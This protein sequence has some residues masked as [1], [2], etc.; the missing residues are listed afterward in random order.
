[1]VFK[2]YQHRRKDTNE[3]FYVGHGKGS[4]PWQFT[5]GRSKSWQA[6]YS[7]YGCVVEVLE[8][9]D[10]K[11][12]A[13]DREI[14][15]IANYRSNGI[16]LVNTKDGGEDQYQ[17]IVHTDETKLK[18]SQARLKTNHARK[19]TKTPLGIFD[20]MVEAAKAHNVHI[21]TIGYRIKHKEGYEFY[22]QSN[23]Q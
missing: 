1:M 22:V 11:Q 18:I 3:I 5:R 20:S 6:I 13:G 12:E 15:L 8:K 14:Q 7:N 9:F 10:T 19:K 17:G 23:T 4:R 16:P 21:D 2:V